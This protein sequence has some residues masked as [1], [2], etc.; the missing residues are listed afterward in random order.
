MKSLNL[1]LDTHTYVYMHPRIEENFLKLEKCL[2]DGTEEG[3]GCF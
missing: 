2:P 1:T 3:M